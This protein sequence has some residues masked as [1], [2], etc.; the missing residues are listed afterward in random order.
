MKTVVK[1]V[2]VFVVSAVMMLG[3]GAMGRANAQMSGSDLLRGIARV[4]GSLAR[5]DIERGR[6]ADAANWQGWA[7]LYQ[8]GAAQIPPQMSAQQMLR[9]NIDFCRQMERRAS[10][11]GHRP[12]AN[13]YRASVAMWQDLLRQ[14]ERGGEVIVHFP[15]EMLIPIPGAPGTPWERMQ[16]RPEV[17]KPLVTTPPVSSPSFGS[18]IQSLLQ[19]L[20]SMSQADVN[21]LIG[22]EH[23]LDQF[24]PW[25]WD[26]MGGNP[27]AQFGIGKGLMG[28]LGTT[29]PSRIFNQSELD[30]IAPLL[31]QAQIMG[32]VSAGI[33]ARD[34]VYS[35]VARYENYRLADKAA[36][37]ALLR[38][39][40]QVQ[41]TGVDP[42]L[43]P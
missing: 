28:T 5:R 39:W 12:L 34:R 2:T 13:L 25:W 6:T 16:V 27:L 35:D 43:E 15:D 11:Q 19:R 41:R 42:N 7:A 31:R 40:A 23:W 20:N 38:L 4:A 26:K 22:R 9:L 24:T 33:A 8:A 32:N 1:V 17:Q 14:V 37:E 30:R 21:R 18:D 10:V 29:D 36:F 3:F